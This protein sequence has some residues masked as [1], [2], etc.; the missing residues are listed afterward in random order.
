MSDQQKKRKSDAS[1]SAANQKA[2]IEI[3][4][5]EMF[6]DVMQSAQEEAGTESDNEEQHQSL[7]SSE[8]AQQTME[9]QL[10]HAE[11]QQEGGQQEKEEQQEEEEQQQEE[12][13]KQMEARPD[14]VLRKR[15]RKMKQCVIPA[16]LQASQTSPASATQEKQETGKFHLPEDVENQ[17]IEWLEAQPILYDKSMDQYRSTEKKRQLWSAKAEHL[18]ELGITCTEKDLSNWFER[19]KALAKMKKD[20]LPSGSGT[21]VSPEKRRQEDLKKR[22]AWLTA[23]LEITPATPARKRRAVALTPA[24]VPPISHHLCLVSSTNFTNFSK[25]ASALFQLDPSDEEEG[26]PTFPSSPMTSQEPLPGPSGGTTARSTFQTVQAA[27]PATPAP[28]ATPSAT[29]PATPPAI[30]SNKSSP[31]GKPS[32]ASSASLLPGL[33]QETDY[34]EQLSEEVV[35]NLDNT[36][37]SAE[38]RARKTFMESGYEEILSQLP[39]DLWVRFLEEYMTLVNTFRRKLLAHR[40]H[41]YP[42]PSVPPT[43]TEHPDDDPGPSCSQMS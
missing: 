31:A 25:Y 38:E 20:P 35:P 40:A 6:K 29:P 21:Q 1:W 34:T 11:E 13:E 15:P 22:L 32:K 26:S 42:D 16:T 9:M 23:F 43:S 5:S 37:L 10:E 27:T 19:M 39:E 24:D 12:Q 2:I 28:A 14:F 8:E 7:W 4:C 18:K 3:L 30:P 33:M 41:Q 17:L 36:V